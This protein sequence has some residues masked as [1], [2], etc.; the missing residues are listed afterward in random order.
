MDADRMTSA[1]ITSTNNRFT[2]IEIELD[3]ELLV[4]AAEEV[5]EDAGD[6]EAVAD[7]ERLLVEV[8][9]LELVTVA[10][11]ALLDDDCT[12]EAEEE[13]EDTPEPAGPTE[14]TVTASVSWSETKTSPLAES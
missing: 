7:D 1:S 12:F 4:A 5:E 9:V 11:D 10:E 3:F 13:E 2:E 8:G 6:V 14:T